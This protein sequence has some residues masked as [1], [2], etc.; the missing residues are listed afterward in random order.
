MNI[1]DKSDLVDTSKL[2]D[3]NEVEATYSSVKIYRLQ[4]YQIQDQAR[5]DQIRVT[6]NDSRHG[7]IFF[8]FKY[9]S[10]QMR[11]LATYEGLLDSLATGKPVSL[12]ADAYQGTPFVG[13]ISGVDIY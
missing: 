11:G 3:K 8:E 5:N 1:K 4:I 2:N 10:E 12:F 9:P 6:L 7:Y 13:Y